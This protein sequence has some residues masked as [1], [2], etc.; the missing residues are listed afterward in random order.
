MEF[1]LI[2]KKLN[3]SLSEED[4]TIFREWYNESDLHKAYFKKVQ[5]NYH[6]ETFLIDIEKGWKA[7]EKKIRPVAVKKTSYLKYAVAASIV[8]L[9]SITFLIKKEKIE[10]VVNPIITNNNIQI[11]TDKATLTLEDGTLV[12]LEKGKQYISD[13]LE[14]NGEEIIYN[15]QTTANKEIAYNYLTIPRG[16][17]YQVKLSDG[18]V[19]WLNSESQLKYPVNF[20][21]GET[22][23]IELVYGEAYF[24]VSPSENH[25]GD[26]FKVL[27]KGQEVEVLGTEFNI[28]AYKD[29]NSIYTTLVEGKVTVTANQNRSTLN[30]DQQAVLNIATR[31]I[32]II[33][34]DTYSEIAWK[35]GLFSFKNKNLKDISKVLSRW[36][37]VDFIF[38]DKSLEQIEFKGVLSKN[39]NIE[40][41]LTL[42]KNTNYINAYD[43]NNTTITIKN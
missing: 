39:Q 1:K 33:Q 41:I 17:Q 13:N 21:E 25:N 2:L 34:V 11:G 5:E 9:I 24:D 12:A 38:E 37:D 28:K 31:K 43:I 30:P 7:V 10:E 19:V 16:G 15:S 36:Y 3:K 14:S 6:D 27:N 23:E 40:E 4:A 26:R 8:L 22:R 18:T 20:I 35:R 29:E 42:I 32:E